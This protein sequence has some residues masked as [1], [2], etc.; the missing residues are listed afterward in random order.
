[1]L[2]LIPYTKANLQF[3][4]ARKSFFREVAIRDHVHEKAARSGFYRAMK[5]GLIE[6]DEKGQIRLTNKGKRR[7]AT[8]TSRYLPNSNLMVI[9]DIAEAERAKRS[10]V[11]ALLKELSFKQVQKSVWVSEYDHRSLVQMEVEHLKLQDSIQVFEC[12]RLS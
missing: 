10:H 11:R 9:F 4:F 2:A 7:I 6:E 12:Y 3:S 5:Q 1:M 8:Y